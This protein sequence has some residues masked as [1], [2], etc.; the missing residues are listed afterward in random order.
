MC[1]EVKRGEGHWIIDS[2]KVFS[3]VESFEHEGVDMLSD[4]FIDRSA[5]QNP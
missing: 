4:Y 1:L 3:G 5:Q 2:L